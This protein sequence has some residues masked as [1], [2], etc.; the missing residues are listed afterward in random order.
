MKRRHK[1]L[2]TAVFAH[3]ALVIC[4]AAT[5]KIPGSNPVSKAVRAYGQISGADSGYGFFAPGVGSQFRFSF[6]MTDAEGN[7]W[8]DDLRFG[9]S[10]EAN[11]RMTGMANYLAH[12]NAG[13]RYL[14]MQSL[15]AKMF[16][17]HPKATKVTVRYDMWAAVRQGA[18]PGDDPIVRLPRMHEIRD[19]AKPEWHTF[20]I[21]AFSRDK[22]AADNAPF[23]FELT[24]TGKDGKQ[25]QETMTVQDLQLLQLEGTD[26]ADLSVQKDRD[27]V[28]QAL[29]LFVL[30]AKAGSTQVTVK[31]QYLDSALAAANEN[32]KSKG[33]VSS[34]P[35][36][37]TIDEQTFKPEK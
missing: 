15:S 27:R 8:H 14:V 26:G 31:F 12:S 6:T 21:Y 22:T 4:G 2:L 13:H 18:N 16:A 20:E 23:R 32:E 34:G 17:R 30:N 36:W 33:T 24:V 35:V 37:K 19:G 3:L 28:L 5:L 9:T 29:A 10:Q 1:I 25:T 11:L 7:Q